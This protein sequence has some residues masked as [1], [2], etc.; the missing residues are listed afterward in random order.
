MLYVLAKYLHVA[1]V[2]LSIAG[3]VVRGLL[4]W[5]MSALARRR[6]ERKVPPRWLRMLP[7]IND[8]LLLAAGLTL[9]VLIGQ[10]P[11]V[12]AWLT[13]K[14]FGLIAYI[15]LGALALKPGRPARVRLAA[16]IA[17]IG[18][19]GWIVSVAL[20]KQPLGWLAALA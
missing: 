6:S 13:A 17:A 10:Y 15:I 1:C 5:R 16:G 7:H 11:F 8:T 20:G 14:F 9:M 4:Q 3:F 12:D 18:V 19:F 2:T